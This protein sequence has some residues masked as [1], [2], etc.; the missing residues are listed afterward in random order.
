[1]PT[2]QQPQKVAAA[3][4]QARLAVTQ[5]LVGLVEA[6]EEVLPAMPGPQVLGTYLATTA[7]LETGRVPRGS[8]VAAAADV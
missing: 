2:P 1:M 8:M 3:D 4:T 7:A 6:E 5:D